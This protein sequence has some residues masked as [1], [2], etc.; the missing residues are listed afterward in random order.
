VAVNWLDEFTVNEAGLP[1]K[2][3][4]ETPVNPDPLMVTE[5]P[6]SPPEGLKELMADDA[7]TLCVIVFEVA[8]FPLTQFRDDDIVQ[9][10]ASPSL[11]EADEYEEP[12]N[13]VLIPFFIHW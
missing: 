8:G 7:I 9:E 2:V 13:P 12:V 1:L 3:T 10:T 11:N 6:G 5:L 4:E